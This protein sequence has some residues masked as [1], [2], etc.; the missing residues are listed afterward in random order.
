MSDELISKLAAEIQTC[1]WL[2]LE[3][4]AL[5]NALFLVDGELDLLTAAKGLA[6]NQTDSVQAWLAAGSIRRPSKDELEVWHLDQ[7][8]VFV[9]LV[10]QPFVLARPQSKFSES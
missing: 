7:H 10:V 8:K 5:R 6:A 1:Y 4:H 3:P 9:F 2:D